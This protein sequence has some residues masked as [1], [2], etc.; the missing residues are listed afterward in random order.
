MSFIS[1][2]GILNHVKA[3]LGS[4]AH[5]L[6]LS[7]SDMVRCLMDNTLK[8]LS[9]YFP[10]MVNVQV[11]A[12][13]DAVV[14]VKDVGTYHIKPPNDDEILGVVELMGLGFAHHYPHA[15]AQPH[16]YPAG[17]LLDYGT[18]TMVEGLTSP[19]TAEFVPPNQVN[20][21]PNP[22]FQD[23]FLLRCKAAHKN[24][25]TLPPGLLEHVRNLA[26][27]DIRLDIL[28]ERQYFTNVQAEF[29]E[30]ELNVGPYEEALGRRDELIQ[31]FTSKQHFSANRKKVWVY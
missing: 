28:G 2:H 26:E 22:A 3:K 31:L 16:R 24:F 8:T 7:D 9:V 4:R 19:H 18:Q 5:K 13:R 10:R 14:G 11:D 17:D 12:K 25:S 29:A 1:T 27:Y 30:I 21:R 20:V 23:Q 15:Y 6:E